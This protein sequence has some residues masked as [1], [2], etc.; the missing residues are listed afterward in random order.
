LV[1]RVD[2]LPGDEHNVARATDRAAKRTDAAKSGQRAGLWKLLDHLGPTRRPTLL[3]G[4]KSWGI[5]RVMARAEQSSLK[6]LFRRRMTLNVQRSR[7]RAMRQSDWADAGQG[8]RARERGWQG[9]ETA[10]RLLGWS[11][12]R[13]IILLRRKKDRDQSVTNPRDIEQLRLGFGEVEADKE[14]WEYAALVTS[15]SDEILTLGQLYRDRADAE[16]GFDELKNQWGWGGF[17]TQDLTRCRLLASTVALV[18]NWWN[19]FVRCAEP[20]RAREALTS[21][22]LL[23][24]AVGRII[25]SGGQTILRLTSSHAEARRIQSVLSG[26]SLFL[27]GLI[28]AAEQLPPEERWRRIW[29]RILAPYRPPAAAWLAPNG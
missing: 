18:Y 23:L 3:R 27:S 14:L 19:L 8:E 28:N 7:Q 4:D 20:E 15:L 6:Y 10:L 17:T 5:E 29:H 16:N 9:K 22:P 1:L 11:R 24:H 26:L 12:Q 13:R 2:V 21:R 25:K